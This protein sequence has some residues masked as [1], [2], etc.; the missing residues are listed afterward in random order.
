MTCIAW[1]GLPAFDADRGRNDAA[2][3]KFFAEFQQR[4]GYPPE[5]VAA[6]TYSAVTLMADAIKRANSADPAKVRDALTAT[7]NYPLLTGELLGFNSLHEVIMP[8]SVNVVADGKMKY[9]GKLGDLE[10]FAPPEK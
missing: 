8:I 7:K 4:A 5:N 1:L 6:I 9:F 3:R 2:L 10:A